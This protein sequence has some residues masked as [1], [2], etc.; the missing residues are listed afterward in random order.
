VQVV[1]PRRSSRL[2]KKALQHTPVVAI[3]QNVLM[4]KM[5]VSTGQQLESADFDK[6]LKLFEEGLSLEQV[7]MIRELFSDAVPVQGD[8]LVMEEEA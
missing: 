8:A 3:V 5:G 4:H 6:Y 7:K 2:A 1:M